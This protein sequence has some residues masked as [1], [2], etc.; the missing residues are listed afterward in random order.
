MSSLSAN[1]DISQNHLSIIVYEVFNSSVNI[2]LFLTVYISE[3]QFPLENKYQIFNQHRL[4][5]INSHHW[6]K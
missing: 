2:I 1:Y 4:L 3:L 5:M 6:E